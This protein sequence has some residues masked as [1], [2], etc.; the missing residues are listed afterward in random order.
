MYIF[1]PM[2]DEIVYVHINVM[3]LVY[4]RYECNISADEW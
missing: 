1:Q 3:T 2:A 4:F